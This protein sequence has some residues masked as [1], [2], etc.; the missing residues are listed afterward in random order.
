MTSRDERA[1]DKGGRPQGEQRPV[2]RAARI[3]GA[4]NGEKERE[5]EKSWT[6]VSTI[7]SDWD[8]TTP[9]LGKTFSSSADGNRGDSKQ[10][11]K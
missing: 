5:R 1:T 4:L 9:F 6:D 10:Q 11:L 3:A 2:L 7:C 8:N